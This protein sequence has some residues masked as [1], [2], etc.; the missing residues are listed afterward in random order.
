[1]TWYFLMHRR[2]LWGWPCALLAGLLVGCSP[3]IVGQWRSI[4]PSEGSPEV[5]RLRQVEFSKD[6][7][8][9]GRMVRSGRIIRLTGTY[10]FDGRQLFLTPDGVAAGGTQVYRVRPIGSV[11]LLTGNNVT[12]RL[13]RELPSASPPPAS[14]LSQGAPPAAVRPA[15]GSDS[16]ATP[17][18]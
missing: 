4:E 10:E 17:R 3:S 11:L 9:Q 18:P 6:G 7:Q 8:C 16:Q 5:P 13:C 2:R 14:D 15:D 12:T 1:M